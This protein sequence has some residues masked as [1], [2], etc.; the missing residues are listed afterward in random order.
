MMKLTMKWRF[1]RKQSVSECDSGLSLTV[2]G[3]M[4]K[5]AR[6]KERYFS[7]DVLFVYQLYLGLENYNYSQGRYLVS[8]PYLQACDLSISTIQYMTYYTQSLSGTGVPNKLN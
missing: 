1:R 5:L 8:S 2:A 7:S 6:Q 4:K 3:E